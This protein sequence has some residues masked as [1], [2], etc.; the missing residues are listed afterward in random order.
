MFHLEGRPHKIKEQSDDP[1]PASFD[2]ESIT[3]EWADEDNKPPDLPKSQMPP[4]KQQVIKK[5]IV[6]DPATNGVVSMER[7]LIADSPPSAKKRRTNEVDKLLG[8]EGVQVIM[9]DQQICFD[10]NGTLLNMQKASKT[11]HQRMR[12][13]EP[14]KTPNDWNVCSMIVRRRSSSFS[15]DSFVLQDTSAN[16]GN[17]QNEVPEKDTVQEFL[18]P[19]LITNLF[20]SMKT[21]MNKTLSDNFDIVVL[22]EE[23][24]NDVEVKES[25]PPTQRPPGFNKLRSNKTEAPKTTP[26]T[27]ASVIPKKTTPPKKKAAIQRPK[28]I[29]VHHYEK[30][31]VQVKIL[32]AGLL[33]SEVCQ[34]I[35]IVLEELAENRNCN[36]VLLGPIKFISTDSVN[37][38]SPDTACVEE[39]RFL[40]ALAKFPKA[41]C[42]AVQ[43]N[44]EGVGVTM[45]PLFDLVFAK[46]GAEFC[47]AKDPLP[48]LSILMSSAKV[49]KNRVSFS[50]N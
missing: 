11:R 18:S 41:I 21:Q 13:E 1:E 7:K 45:L 17:G 5:K 39:R 49:D 35:V 12:Q 23:T 32:E 14:E 34:Q 24:N 29:S 50:A 40:E 46:Y 10:D 25:E 4:T 9:R 38:R 3:I 6:W 16:T 42:A 30:E 31:F 20:Q 19:P 15:T 22:E 28:T 48:G 43:G 37:E 8:D 27:T 44:V 2:F 33:S 47:C 36:L 26:I